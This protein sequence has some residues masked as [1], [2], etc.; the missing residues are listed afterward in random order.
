MRSLGADEFWFVVLHLLMPCGAVTDCLET[1][2]HF[3]VGVVAK[4]S[5]LSFSLM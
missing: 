5:A 2:V 1:A 3:S 4:V